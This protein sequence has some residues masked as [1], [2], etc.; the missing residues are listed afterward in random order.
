M[1]PLKNNFFK[2]L[3][4]LCFTL[5]STNIVLAQVALPDVV[6]PNKSSAQ[7]ANKSNASTTTTA[8]PTAGEQPKYIATEA[9]GLPS[10]L[11]N[12]N[13][14]TGAANITVPMKALTSYHSSLPISLNYSATGIKVDQLSGPTGLGWNLN[15]GGQITRQII[16]QADDYYDEY[17]H[18]TLPVPYDTTE[19]SSGRAG[20][21]RAR[22]YLYRGRRQLRWRTSHTGVSWNE[23][24]PVYPN[25]AT[26]SFHTD[27][28]TTNPGTALRYTA[29]IED[30]ANMDTQSDI[31]SFNFGNYSGSFVINEDGVPVFMGNQQD[32]Q[33]T[34]VLDYK[35]NPSFW[36][37]P[38]NVNAYLDANPNDP[39]IT[40]KM[41]ASNRGCLLSFTIHT[42]DGMKYIFESRSYLL[43]NRLARTK[44][45][46]G[47]V[48]HPEYQAVFN[49]PDQATLPFY[50]FNGSDKSL[51]LGNRDISGNAEGR[52]S[53]YATSWH[54]T[55]VE[56]I[57]G[58]TEYNLDY[59]TELEANHT[60]ISA[61]I[62]KQQTFESS[63]FSTSYDVYAQKRIKTINS[64]VGSPQAQSAEFVYGKE[65]TTADP[66]TLRLASCLGGGTGCITGNA[67]LRPDLYI[68]NDLGEIMD[69]LPITAT[70]GPNGLGTL[71]KI[72]YKTN[73]TNTTHEYLLEYSVVGAASSTFN[74]YSIAHAQRNF[75]RKVTEQNGSTTL[76][77]YQFKY[78][79][80]DAGEATLPSRNSTRKDYWGYSNT[81]ANSGT[82][83]YPFPNIFTYGVGTETGN[84]TVGDE[85][86]TAYSIFSRYSIPALAS[87]KTD[88][89]VLFG[90]KVGDRN[91]ALVAL[92]L[93]A[94]PTRA[95]VLKKVEMPTGGYMEL[96][97]ESNE[98][99]LVDPT[100]DVVFPNFRTPLT[101][102][103]AAE[104][105][106]GL[107][108]KS[109]KYVADPAQPT[110]AYTRTYLYDEPI[111]TSTAS[112]SGT[113]GRLIEQPRYAQYS[114]NL[115]N[116]TGVCRLTNYDNATAM[117]NGYLLGYG[118]VTVKDDI[119]SVTTKYR[120][121]VAH[122]IHSV[123]IPP[124]NVFLQPTTIYESY[125]SQ[126]V[127]PNITSDRT[128]N[129]IETRLGPD[130]LPI[131]PKLPRS[132]MRWLNEI[133]DQQTQYDKN[134]K[135]VKV[136][137]YTYDIRP[138]KVTNFVSHKV[139]VYNSTTDAD[140]GLYLYPPLW[141]NSQP[142]LNCQCINP[143]FISFALRYSYFYLPVVY[144]TP[145][146]LMNSAK[147][148]LYEEAQVNTIE[149]TV[150]YVY[151]PTDAGN[152]PYSVGNM[153]HFFPTQINMTNSDG[154]LYTT[155]NAYTLTDKRDTWKNWVNKIKV[156]DAWKNFGSTNTA[157][158]PAQAA[159]LIKSQTYPIS[160]D[161]YG[162]TLIG[163]V[164]Y[165][166]ANFTVGAASAER[167]IKLPVK[168]YRR[169]NVSGTLRW[170]ADAKIVQYTRD[171]YPS[172][173][174]PIHEVIELDFS[175]GVTSPG[176]IPNTNPVLYQPTKKTIWVSEVNTAPKTQYLYAADNTA[177]P[178]TTAA[179]GATLL[180]QEI[181]N[182]GSLTAELKTQYFYETTNANL[183][184]YIVT[185][186]GITI[187][188]DYDALQRVASI[189]TSY[190]TNTQIGLQTFT[191]P[192]L[193]KTTAKTEYAAT[194]DGFGLLEHYTN[195]LGK[196]TKQVAIKA[197]STGTDWTQTMQYDNTLRLVGIDNPL[198]GSTPSVQ[199][200]SNTPW[201]MITRAAGALVATETTF[202][203]NVV[204]EVM[205][206]NTASSGY[207]AK[208]LVKQIYKD[209][210][211]N[212]SMVYSDKLGRTI[213]TRRVMATGN[214]DTYYK[215]NTVGDLVLV[216]APGTVI[217]D[218]S[219]NSF[220]KDET[221]VLNYQYE[222][223]P[224]HKLKSKALPDQYNGTVRLKTTYEYDYAN[225]GSRL[226]KMTL[227]D[228]K[229]LTYTYDAPLNGSTAAVDGFGN[230][231]EVKLDG[232]TTEKYFLYG[233]TAIPT[234]TPYTVPAAG[235]HKGKPAA[236]I[237]YIMNTNGTPS[238]N[239]L[240]SMMT[241]DAIGRV[242]TTTSVNTELPHKEQTTFAYDGRSRVITQSRTVK[243][244]TNLTADLTILKSYDYETYASTGRYEFGDRLLGVRMKIG[245][246]A[247]VTLSALNYDAT[248]RLIQQQM[249]KL[250]T[251]PLTA[252]L[253][254]TSFAYNSE[255][256]LIDINLLSGMYD[257][258][259][260]RP[261]AP[262]SPLSGET[263]YSYETQLLIEQ[264]A[265]K[266]AAA[267]PTAIKIHYKHLT[268]ANNILQNSEN[269]DF[270][271]PLFGL[272]K[273]QTDPL[274]N[275]KALTLK[276]MAVV[277]DASDAIAQAIA[278]EAKSK[279][280]A[281][282]L[283]NTDLQALAKT[284]NAA[285]TETN[286]LP[287]V[288]PYTPL[289]AEHID[290]DAVGNVTQVFWNDARYANIQGYA[291]TYDKL[292]RLL[293][294]TYN[295]Y[296]NNG[297]FVLI[298]G[299]AGRYNEQI[300]Y[301]DARGN[302][303]NI[304]RYGINN[305][306]ATPTFGLI[307]DITMTY[308]GN[309]LATVKDASSSVFGFTPVNSTANA[310]TYDTKG[311]LT[312]D[313]SRGITGVIYN[314]LDQPISIAVTRSAISG[315]ITLKYA[316][317]GTLIQKTV[318]PNT[319]VPATNTATIYA[320]G[321]EYVR[322]NNAATATL[323]S[324]YHDNGRFLYADAIASAATIPLTD[325]KNVLGF[326][327]FSLSDHLGNTR[328][329]FRD[330]NRD[331][332][333]DVAT[334]NAEVTQA[335]HYYATG[336]KMK[337]TW[338]N[339]T[340]NIPKIPYLYNGND[341]VED[342]AL[343]IYI[344]PNR[345]LDPALFRFWQIDPAAEAYPDLSPYNFAFCNPLT[346][347]DPSGA[348]PN[349][350]P[351]EGGTLRTVTVT[352]KR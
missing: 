264:D 104:I 63:S 111:A 191:Y 119:G 299:S 284:I 34:Y 49:Q 67:Y 53:I 55:K 298:P 196:T 47:T 279:G 159:L 117:D 13:L 161:I 171:A 208:R 316:A 180:R 270:T 145:I 36:Y 206:V 202:G 300:T 162:N 77:P 240:Y 92:V 103:L 231:T 134:G 48:E 184:D 150:S 268:F 248:D 116:T 222:Y 305:T 166:Y 223:Y 22:G 179:A 313:P 158:D 262:T 189:K 195:G 32:L 283:T 17:P 42:P 83:P 41:T 108:I 62:R 241:Y 133:V 245:T 321:I 25:G 59:R 330:T 12:T 169:E 74:V 138:L 199:D 302:V 156:G 24:N 64:F 136:V 295:E 172:E 327:Q 186:D 46:V 226:I 317:D 290:Y 54:L 254:S 228:A 187:N 304:K 230:L 309:R 301:N 94:H 78:H 23:N 342:L 207:P 4:A 306:A 319:T 40:K 260:C 227:P 341:L 176:I 87:K 19:L 142:S 233:N 308:A 201:K 329:T 173:V 261:A 120:N 211:G 3:L 124:Q 132:N 84:S 128:R 93:L 294:T 28:G 288:I 315:T 157:I 253:Q 278:A 326:H 220:S 217:Y 277:A 251:L 123:V 328:V 164:F 266:V 52:T 163:G 322:L 242:A 37:E 144:N 114:W 130:N 224:D 175:T 323:T 112:T 91:P 267:A 338:E 318:T 269:R 247:E 346:F 286:S 255:K 344:T 177:T 82:F 106:P 303:S 69:V 61:E 351:K 274:P 5:T 183:M 27:I 149:S 89:A 85:F 292:N 10:G 15:A 218:N 334:S 345:I 155:F 249:G 68:P 65:G 95:G 57:T 16:G 135:I 73:T 98:Y 291:A 275:S 352:A 229:V 18:P 72:V 276:G 178:T 43:K 190:G 307:D 102:P 348:D 219:D 188:S 209:E 1:Y 332:V 281:Y 6:A 256:Q 8:V 38:D 129:L 333:I 45:L 2:T 152:Y 347:N 118:Q 259:G 81:T 205:D 263:V 213:M 239:Y 113:S 215:Y 88:D 31:Y 265:E 282:S 148:T 296:T 250:P 146:V 137:D 203:F 185:P 105:G 210:N 70:S 197:S 258:S 285:M 192:T 26:F 20:R 33:I 9:N 350:E 331:G 71:R 140:V 204:N 340:A 125:S 235:L 339:T 324:I 56:N 79:G 139:D 236:S 238:A 193:N 246:T 21:A 35:Y 11:L 234:I 154:V 325:P 289:F 153:P 349:D 335:V 293:T 182:P 243:A 198:E 314:Y 122:G 160:S 221:S 167:S 252:A 280:S 147:T 225:R 320:D 7:T 110:K 115:A 273:P 29:Y 126:T 287:P 141:T 165:D 181:Y 151:E 272:Q 143:I 96:L 101:N 75:L 90:T 237:A 39:R 311:N 121:A 80:D 66:T 216:F 271:I 58:T 194:A 337:G 297:C 200:Y 86:L 99:R 257:R 170:I 60:A 232:A 310:I 109:L 212:I 14:H 343:G 97:T 50:E 336:M 30:D 244:S 168:V 107:R 100:T 44:T 76:P 51:D 131:I 214:A 312:T 127:M 174:Q